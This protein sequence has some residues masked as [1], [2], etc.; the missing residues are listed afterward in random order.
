MDNV[1]HI[2]RLWTLD[3]VAA[4]LH[5][6]V[7]TVRAWRKRGYG[8]PGRKMGK[9]LRYDPAVVREWFANAA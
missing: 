7:E 1:R 9:H 4:F 2:E 6:S 5:V 3:D 8:P